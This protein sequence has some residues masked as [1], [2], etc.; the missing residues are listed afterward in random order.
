MVYLWFEFHCYGLSFDRLFAVTRHDAPF[1]P[2]KLYLMMGPQ[3]MVDH[4]DIGSAATDGLWH[5]V[6]LTRSAGN[7]IAYLDGEELTNFGRT[8]AHGA[9]SPMPT[10]TT[11]T[12]EGTTTTIATSTETTSM[13][14]TETTETSAA[15]TT[16][17]AAMTSTAEVWTGMK[18][19]MVWLLFVA[20]RYIGGMV[21]V[22]P[23]FG[24]LGEVAIREG[25]VMTPALAKK[26]RKVWDRA[27]R[28]QTNTHA[29]QTRFFFFFSE[30][31]LL[32]WG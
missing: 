13:T 25:Y 4:W 12:T 20:Y 29:A 3:Y 24:L 27:G 17:T 18:N 28:D 32:Y 8:S 26:C 30:A 9:I 10:A 1:L 23:F 2:G 11:G 6:V 31:F 21:Q 15:T 7:L 16:S 22:G 14:S 5:S 19:A